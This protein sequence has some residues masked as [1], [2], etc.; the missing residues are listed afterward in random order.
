MGWV[1]WHSGRET[2][3]EP[4]RIASRTAPRQGPG[5]PPGVT[6]SAPPPRLVIPTNLVSS[7]A[8]SLP[9]VPSVAATG[10]LAVVPA[11]NQAPFL[12]WTAPRPAA[13][14][15]EVQ[16][17]LARLGFS[18]GPM[19]GSLGSQTRAAIRAF[20]RR[21]RLPMTGQLDSSTRAR[22]IISSPFITTWTVSRDDVARLRP[23]SST[24]LGKSRQERLDY[25]TLLELVS[26]KTWS[27]QAVLRQLNPGVNW[28]TLQPGATLRVPNV[29]TPPKARVSH[30]RI[31]LGERILQ[32]FDAGS[33][34]LFHFPCSVARLVQK[35]PRGTLRVVRVVP[36]PN[37]TFNPEVFPE[38]AEGR[39]LGRKLNLP[40]GPNNPVGIAWI[41]LDRPGYGIHGTPRPED[42]G[43]TESHGCFRLANWN[44]GYLAEVVTVG[45]PVFVDP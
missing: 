27:Y 18:P 17:T 43:R 22:L 12:E 15:L 35:R 42:V 30:L 13:T 25:E 34:L 32:G 33:G 36:N 7:P 1:F 44:A 37:Y 20:Q 28:S 6:T 29:G 4:A 26:E 45:T 10:A 5:L 38:S 31:Q 16:L 40:P 23:L 11:I 14:T 8:A 24:W 39:R 2:E 19:D 21:E 9:Q 3:P 41:G